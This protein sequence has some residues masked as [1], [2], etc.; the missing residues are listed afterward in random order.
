MCRL[1]FWP[2]CIRLP[3]R[4]FRPSVASVS[5]CVISRFLRRSWNLCSLS[6]RVYA[7]Q[8][9]VISRSISV[10]VKVIRSE[11][12]ESDTHTH[13]H[14]HTHVRGIITV[15]SISVKQRIGEIIAGLSDMK[16]PYI[17]LNW[18]ASRVR[19]DV[20][21]RWLEFFNTLHTCLRFNDLYVAY[22]SIL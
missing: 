13:T 22:E 1:A 10:F 2:F 7:L 21:I 15:T 9:L 5:Q 4:V 6:A 3:L 11:N 18:L 12:F 20:L 16:E 8:A 19:R 17:L 14:T